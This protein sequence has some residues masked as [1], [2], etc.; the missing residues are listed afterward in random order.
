MLIVNYSGVR[1]LGT[2]VGGWYRE[3]H[4]RTTSV[5]VEVP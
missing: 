4:S 5:E 1:K 3:G 2:R